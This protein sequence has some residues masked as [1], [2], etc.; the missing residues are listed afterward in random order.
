VTQLNETEMRNAELACSA[1][2]IEYAEIVDNQ[3]YVR[4]RDIFAEDAVFARPTNPQENLRGVDEIVAMFTSRPRNRLTHH[5]ISNIRIRL[6][7][8][9]T[10]VGTCRVLLFTTDAAE[11]E[12]PEGR[13][14]SPKQL[15]GTYHDR[16][17][18]TRNGWRF[19]ERRGGI[20]LHT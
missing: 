3:D 1:L 4:L 10:A 14:A 16:Y 13:K 12:T 19:A 17:V 2:V 9:D 18:R 8:A 7:T 15:M 11:P 20:S 6:E 5:I